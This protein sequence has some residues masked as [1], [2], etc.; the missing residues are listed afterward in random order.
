MK[1]RPGKFDYVF[2]FLVFLDLWAMYLY[3]GLRL[4]TKPLIVSSLLLYYIAVAGDHQ[5]PMVMLGL[6][7]AL[8]GDIFLMF[9]YPMFFQM[10]L[11]SFLVM[12]LCYT[13]IFR[14]YKG[15]LSG[16][17][18][19]GIAFVILVAACFNLIFGDRFGD[20]RWPV[21]LY[22]AAISAMVIAAIYQ[23]NTILITWGAILFMVSDLCLAFHKFVAA[24][25]ADG[26]IVM[27]TYAA[28]Q[29]LI[30]K[31]FLHPFQ[32]PANQKA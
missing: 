15:G 1:W 7:F 30:V 28:A 22:T 20:L 12:Q 21:L 26:L 13:F 10:G 16:R 23:R 8:L 11:A 19:S 2:F 32:K 3:P 14:K 17:S 29:Y 31:G 24:I 6:I 9:D 4:L 27:L 18:W 5:Q 25:P